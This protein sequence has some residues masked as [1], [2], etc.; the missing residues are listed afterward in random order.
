MS[1][2]HN[3]EAMKKIFLFTL[4]L[5]SS[6]FW[7]SCDK[8]VELLADYEDIPIVYGLINPVDSISYLR[9]E[10]AFL[11]DGDVF[12]AAAI[13]DSNL[14]SYKLNV[15]LYSDNVSITFDTMTVH[16]KEGGIFYAPDMMV[17]YAVTN[18]L[19]N[20]D[21]EYFLE[22]TN[23][24]TGTIV[25]SSS[26][27]IDGSRMNIDYPRNKISFDGDNSIEF[28]SIVN[29]R[30]YDVNLR[31]HY[32]E[33]DITTNDTTW[34]YVDWILPS[35][36]SLYLTGGETMYFL[37]SGDAFYAN[38]LQNIPVNNSVF[39]LT[40]DCDVIVSVADETFNVYMDVNSPSTSLVI[41]RPSY[42]NIENGYGV[43]ASRTY[44]VKTAPLSAN[45]ITKLRS[46][47]ELN[48]R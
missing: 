44:K 20:D 46:Y 37:Y 2:Y 15:R 27:L 6:L 16:N 17:Y 22:I 1:H 14:Y 38:L 39:R 40:G 24:V 7:M 41:D 12:E 42:T 43:F 19:L 5:V 23:P 36:T 10:K 29:G 31:Y 3:F 48:F 33:V 25:T 4:L 28:E 35:Q 8:D 32:K 18:E 34:H 30:L 13:A 47:E 9:I 21:D 45:S 11:T 26:S